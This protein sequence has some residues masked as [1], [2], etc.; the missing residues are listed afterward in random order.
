MNVARRGPRGAADDRSLVASGEGGSVGDCQIVAACLADE[1][2]GECQDGENKQHEL[3]TQKLV[4]LLKAVE[5]DSNLKELTWGGIWRSLVAEMALVK[6]QH[7]SLTGSYAR[8]V[9][10]GPPTDGDTGYGVTRLNYTYTLDAGA[11]FGV[12]EGAKVAVYGIEPPSFPPLGS[13]AR[14]GLLVR[15][16][17]RAKS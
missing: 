15:G 16:A 14:L 11:L 17:P 10:G 9:F 2:A 13:P 5:N 4:A 3:L 12:T 1:S 7:A 6:P 8:R